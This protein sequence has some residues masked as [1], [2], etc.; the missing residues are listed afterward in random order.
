[1]NR[2]PI[3]DREQPGP[4]IFTEWATEFDFPLNEIQLSL[5][6]FTLRTILRMNLRV[7]QAN[8][9]VL[10]RPL[11]SPRVHGDGHRG[12]RTQRRKKEIVRAGPGRGAA[13]RDR[14][15]GAKVMGACVDFLRESVRGAVHDDPA[16][17]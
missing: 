10:E 8:R 2:T 7:A 9:N 3:R 4:L 5:F 15:I 6:R 11:L 1:M 12:A 17:A 13:L 16:L 14:F